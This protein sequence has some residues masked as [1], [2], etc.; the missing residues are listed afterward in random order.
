M[1]T[2]W[3]ND[4]LSRIGLSGS[5]LPT[6][7]VLFSLHKSHVFS[8]PFENLD[9]QLGK[10]ISIDVGENYKKVVEN[11]RGGYC[12]EVNSLFASLLEYVGFDV[13]YHGS[14]VW[15]GYN[16]DAGIRPRAHQILIVTVA[17]VE[18]LVDVS[19]GNGMILPLQLDTP[20]PQEQFGRFYRALHDS[21]LGTRV[22]QRVPDGWM[23]LFSFTREVCYPADYEVASF[24]ASR[25]K[26][27][28]FTQKLVCTKPDERGRKIIL[29]REYSEVYGN[30]RKTYQIESVQQLLKLLKNEFGIDLPEQVSFHQFMNDCR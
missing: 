11:K 28:I 27:S 10:S 5:L 1:K 12:F 29:N 21:K 24:Y 26:N 20:E 15:Y 23:L 2:E 16:S 3:I 30:E 13:T 19:F 22:E 8:V 25:N 7:D 4:Y 6:R 18:Y 14:R 17:G 9:I